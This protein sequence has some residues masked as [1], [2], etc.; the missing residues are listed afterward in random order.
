MKKYFF[1]LVVMTGVLMALSRLGFGKL[2]FEGSWTTSGGDQNFAWYQTYDFWAG[3]YTLSGYP[4]ISESGSYS[5]V[6]KDGDSYVVLMKKPDGSD[7]LLHL[8]LESDG[9]LL[10]SSYSATGGSVF[11]PE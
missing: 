1:L 3:H 9:S 8:A 6:M 7:S 2:P 5:V 11:Q 10:M 4:P